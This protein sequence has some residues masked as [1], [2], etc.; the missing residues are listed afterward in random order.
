M[1][2]F[3]RFNVGT[4]YSSFAAA[5]AIGSVL[6]ATPVYGQQKDED[7]EASTAHA[8]MKCLASE[9][10]MFGIRDDGSRYAAEMVPFSLM[11]I[12]DPARG[13][14]ANVEHHGEVWAWSNGG[15]PV[16]VAEIWR[17]G[18]SRT[19]WGHTMCSTSTGRVA[20][21]ID[22]RT[23]VPKGPGLTFQPLD[24]APPPAA[25]QEERAAQ[26]AHIATQFSGYEVHRNNRVDLKLHSDPI[27]QYQ[28]DGVA[29]SIFAISHFYNPEAL[30]IIETVDHPAAPSTWRYA[31]AQ[32]S[33]HELHIEHQGQ[34]V[35]KIPEAVELVGT[36]S[37]PF[38]LVFVNRP[39]DLSGRNPAIAP[40][41]SSADESTENSDDAPAAQN[42]PGSKA[43]ILESD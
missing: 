9:I 39:V 23:W 37:D 3:H 2:Q 17:W 12:Y 6:C 36:P 16:A 22:G 33:S 42:G 13:A 29:G 14:D 19:R 38:W 4:H 10:K 20:A 7:I 25:D 24:K 35:A 5:L 43:T 32:L 26:A 15:R 28:S 18:R 11:K 1:A 8:F 30:L 40:N 31:V 34:E 21:E 27:Y 41:A